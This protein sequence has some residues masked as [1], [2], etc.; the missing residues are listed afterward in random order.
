[1][2][3]F[4]F[5]F[6]LSISLVSAISFS[7][8][9]LKFDLEKNEEKCENV[10]ITSES[11]LGVNDKW[12]ENADVEWKVSNFH[13]EASSH[14]LSLVYEKEISSEEG[15]VEVCLSGENVGEYHG[16]LLIKEGQVG[17][18][19]TQAGV[20]LTVN[21]GEELQLNTQSQDTS[22]GS[23]SGNSNSKKEVTEEPLIEEEIIE[24]E[25]I[26]EVEEEIVPEVFAKVVD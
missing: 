23:S 11:I 7:P 13:E 10:E 15:I 6:I 4:L 22:S 12:A 14:G 1:M 3:F 26:E 24:D 18:T 2:K 9:S 19:I 25:P 16:V 8:S 17:N 5:F 21:I 20:W